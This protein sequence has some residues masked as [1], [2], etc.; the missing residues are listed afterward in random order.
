MVLKKKV[1]VWRHEILPYSETFIKEQV[2]S[3]QRW[4]PVLAGVTRNPGLDLGGIAARTFGSTEPNLV[5][6]AGW[7]FHRWRNTMPKN[8]VRALKADMASVLHAH[9]G[10]DAV[11]AWPAAKAIGLPMLVTLHGYDITIKRAWWEA[12]HGG[13]LNMKYPARLLRLG[14]EPSVCFIAV[15]DAIKAEAIA[16]GIPADKLTTCYIGIDTAK[17]QPGLKSITER[18]RRVLFVGRLVEKKGCIYLLEAMREVS[19]R[20]PGAELVVVGDGTL[21]NELIRFVAAHDL[22]VRFLGRLTPPE[23][24]RELDMSRVFCLPSVRAQNG[25]LEGLPIAILEAQSCGVPVVTSASG[26]A[27]EGIEPGATGFAFTERDVGALA[28]RLI[29][30]LADDVLATRL[31]RR[32]SAFIAEKFDIR[33]CTLRLEELYDTMATLGSRMK[34]D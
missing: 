29:S 24:K 23:V 20:L 2:R 5:E 31:S 1:V 26:G 34:R 17:F 13:P 28:E 15:S 18:P 16:Y 25:D 3:Y 7:A 8:V 12:G 4:E 33:L 19:A 10:T 27:T 21:R 6:R 14:Q 11:R 9:F 32:A 22:P 30:I